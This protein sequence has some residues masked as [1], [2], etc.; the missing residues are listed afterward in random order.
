MYDYVEG[1]HLFK[2]KRER[3]GCWCQ[4]PY[5]PTSVPLWSDRNKHS[6]YIF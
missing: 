2:C 4:C 3:S 1:W 5:T 6:K